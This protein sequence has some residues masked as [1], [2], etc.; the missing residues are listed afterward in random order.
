VARLVGFEDERSP[1]AVL[2]EMAVQA[3]DREVEFAVGVPPDVEIGFVE[4]PVAGFLREGV[5]G[6]PARLVEPE[7]VGIGSGEVVE[8]GELYRADACVKVRRNWVHG[9]GHFQLY[10][11]AALSRTRRA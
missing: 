3:I 7:A 1:V 2:G 10:S 9:F 11:L 4:R 8:L 5:P 6:Q